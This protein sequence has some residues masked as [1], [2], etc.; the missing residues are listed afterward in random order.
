ME[1][2]RVLDEAAS[3]KR[4]C[5][6]DL[7]WCDAVEAELA[8]TRTQVEEMHHRIVNDVHRQSISSL[9]DYRRRSERRL[10]ARPQ[11]RIIPME[12]SF[13]QSCSKPR[14]KVVPNELKSFVPSKL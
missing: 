5:D 8:S 4:A 2:K 1:V 13:A 6:R 12:K 9:H 14:P 3:L 7:E 11:K 10:A